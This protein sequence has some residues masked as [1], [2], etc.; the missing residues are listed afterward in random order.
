MKDL[1]LFE[2]L[3]PVRPGE[4]NQY[5]YTY[6]GLRAGRVETGRAA[7]KVFYA[8]R[9]TEIVLDESKLPPCPL[10]RVLVAVHEAG[11]FW[12]GDVAVDISLRHMPWGEAESDQEQLA[13]N[14]A[15]QAGR[16]L[17]EEEQLVFCLEDCIAHLDTV[18]GCT[19]PDLE[20]LIQGMSES[21]N[22]KAQKLSVA[23]V[24][25]VSANVAWFK[26]AAGKGKAPSGQLLIKSK[27]PARKKAGT[28]QPGRRQ[29]RT[30]EGAL[31]LREQ[32]CGRVLAMAPAGGLRLSESG[33]R[34]DLE[35]VRV[36]EVFTT[37]ADDPNRCHFDRFHISKETGL[38]VGG[39]RV[40]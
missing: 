13:W 15:I 30:Q 36:I 10:L 19:Q 6:T 7:L 23:M 1:E 16:K 25:A 26:K 18:T 4:R 37:R 33:E 24:K 40:F 39:E 12:E 11:H 2:E 35:S 3:L 38:M 28:R 29:L 21:G 27:A 34:V 31:V 20:G 17:I 14:W 8:E 32:N 22:A 5:G 9:V